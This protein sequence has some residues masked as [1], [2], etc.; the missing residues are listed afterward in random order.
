MMSPRESFWIALGALRAHPMRSLLTM[1][2]IIIGVSAVITMVG[3]GAGAQ[4][5]VAEQIRSLGNNGKYGY[6]GKAAI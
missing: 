4:A 3:V 1:L 2:G 6:R 5:R